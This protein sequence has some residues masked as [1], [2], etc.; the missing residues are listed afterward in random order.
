MKSLNISL[1]VILLLSFVS[2]WNTSCQ[3]DVTHDPL[4]KKGA[5]EI[6]TKKPDDPGFVENAMVIYWNRKASTVLEN[7]NP[8]PAQSRLLQ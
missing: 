7:F 6:M 5:E 4:S 1:I 3:K 8:P 2:L